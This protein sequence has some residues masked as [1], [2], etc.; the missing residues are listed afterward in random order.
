MEPGIQ[1]ARMEVLLVPLVAEHCTRR[2]VKPEARATIG[3]RT[4][5]MAAI[6]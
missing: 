4:E 6:V 5:A 3:A 2:P 1:V